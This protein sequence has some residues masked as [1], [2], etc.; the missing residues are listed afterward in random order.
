M[1]CMSGV[2]GQPQVGPFDIVITAVNDQD[3]QQ[4]SQAA[5]AV[6]AGGESPERT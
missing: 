2:K 6:T 5:L 1:E 4:R 3:S